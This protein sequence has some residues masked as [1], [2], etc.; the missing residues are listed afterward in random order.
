MNMH[1]AQPYWLLAGLVTVLV[2]S[3]LLIRAEYLRSRALALLGGTRLGIDGPPQE[4]FEY[5]QQRL[6]LVQRECLHTARPSATFM[7]NHP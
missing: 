7:V 2:V 5:R 3:T 4:G 6:R 1:F